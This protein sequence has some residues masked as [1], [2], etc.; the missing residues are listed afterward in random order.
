MQ[1]YILTHYKRRKRNSWTARV[2]FRNQVPEKTSPYLLLG[3]QD[4]RVGA[5]QD[6]LF[7]WVHRNLFWH[8]SRDGNFHGSGISHTTTA[9]P[10][11]SFRTL[12]RVGVAV[13]GG[14]NAGWTTSKSGHPCPCQNK[15]L[16]QKR[17]EED[18]C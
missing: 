11:R 16:L 7:L 10:N 14:R 9:S 2:L 12:W 18:L 8:L 1:S 5:E 13:V 3:A 17:L 6:E 4:Q 15:S